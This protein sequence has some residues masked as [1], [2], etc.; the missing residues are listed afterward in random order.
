[1]NQ[2]SE[3]KD[4]ITGNNASAHVEDTTITEKSTPS[5]G[6]P[7]IG[8]QVSEIN[9][10]PPNSLRTVEVIMGAHPVDNGN[11]WGNTNPTDV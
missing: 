7:S 3:G 10:Q 8:A 11:F 6:T 4:S 1:M 9:I 2:T 5:N